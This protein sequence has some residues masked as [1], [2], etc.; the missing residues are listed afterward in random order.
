MF[1][2]SHLQFRFVDRRE[3]SIHFGIEV[4][5]VSPLLIRLDIGHLGEFF[6]EE[7]R[8]RMRV[9]VTDFTYGPISDWSDIFVVAADANAC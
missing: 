2:D 7:D 4:E 9:R 8:Q 1:G 3:S 5:W 6:A